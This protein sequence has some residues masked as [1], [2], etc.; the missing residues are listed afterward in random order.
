MYPGKHSNMFMMIVLIISVGTVSVSLAEESGFFRFPDVRDDLVVFTSEGDLWAATLTGGDAYRLTRHDG[1]ERYARISPDKK[2]IAFT[3][4]YDGNNDVYLIPAKGGEPVRLTFH[5]ALDEVVGWTDDSKHLIFRSYRNTPNYTWKLYKVGLDGGYPMDIGL[6][7]ATRISYESGGDNFAYTRLRREQRPWKRYKG[8]WAMDIWVGNLK[9][10]DFNLVTDFDGTDAYP[11]WIGDRI[12]FLSDRSGRM[13]IFSMNADGSG[14][15][16]HT[17]AEKWDLRWPSGDGKT[18]VYQKAMDIYAYDVATGKETLIDIKLPSDRFRLRERLVGS[19]TKYID[20]YSIPNTGKRLAIASRGEV[21]T[22]PVEESGYIRRLTYTNEGRERYVAFSPDGKTVAMMSDASGEDE[23]WL[24]PSDGKEEPKKLTSGG[25]MYRYPMY[26]S[27]D[28]EYLMFDDK[29]GNLWLVDADSGKLTKIDTAPDFI[30]PMEWS[31]DS[32]W[33]AWIRGDENYNTDVW[34]YNIE[35]KKKFQFDRPMTYE[36]SM[37]WDPDGDYLYFLSYTYFNPVLDQ[38][39]FSYINDRPVKAY[40]VMLAEDTKNPFAPELVEAFEDEEEEE[41]NGEDEE[42]EDNGED[43]EEEDLITIDFDGIYD[44]IYQVDFN[45]GNFFSIWAVSGKFYVGSYKNTGMKEEGEGGKGFTLSIFDLEEEEL[46]KV[47]SGCK[48]F[49]LSPDKKKAVVRTDGG[50]FVVMDAGS[51]KI[52][53]E[54]GHVSLGG[55]DVDINPR[56]EWAL[57]LREIWRWQ[58][59]FFYD[60]GMHGVNWEAVWKQYSSL[61]PRVSNRD[62]LNDLISEMIGELNIGHAYIWGGDIR[63]APRVSVGYLGADLEATNS[64]AYKITRVLKGDGWGD[65]PASPLQGVDE[66]KYIVAIDGVPLEKGD[67]IFERLLGK[68]GQEVLLSLNSTPKLKDAEELLVETLGSEGRLRYLDWVRDRREY[69]DKMTDGKIGYIHL[70]DM[71][72]MGLSM[73]SRMFVPQ[74]YKDG[75]VIDVRHNGGGFVA[76]MILAQ[77]E[78]SVWARGKGREGA[79]GNTPWQSFYGP[80]AAVCNHETGSDGETFS[81]GFKRL[82]LGTLFGTRTWGGWVGIQ[83]GRAT[84]DRGANTQPQFSGWGAFDGQWLIEGPGVYPDVVVM[85]DPK[86]MI[87]GKDPQLD[88][89]IKYVQRE[90]MNTEKWPPFVEPPAYPK[91]PLKIQHLK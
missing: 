29:A 56:D 61:L 64:G 78:H 19:P 7:K 38:V 15:S 60:P 50:S 91:K 35:T 28:G 23:I 18:I 75:L 22:F 34:I 58:R 36:Q 13:N 84:V 59:D 32:K 14:V 71:M 66:G 55:W 6:D 39:D 12:Y 8:G 25:D 81:E 33:I 31:P 88:A 4:E 46:N 37:S 62:E 51:D 9:T 87:E 73:W 30:G 76:Q 57:I 16:Q 27:P 42:E 90:L 3:G 72:G 70:P 82:N 21:F 53:E 1:Q 41:E 79:V 83:G 11:M 44:R 67:N 89:A 48:G 85:D 24:M 68:S 69:V 74:K 20:S 43:E 63:R 17:F 47:T 54:D 52:P 49:A 80:K 5:S 26:W 10:M 77:L 65:E 2:W 86:S 40:I 45:A